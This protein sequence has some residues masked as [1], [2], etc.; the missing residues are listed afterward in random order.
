MP[1]ARTNPG[2]TEGGTVE[3]SLEFLSF[4][5]GSLHSLWFPNKAFYFIFWQNLIYGLEKFL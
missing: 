1:D 5:T 3:G 2:N 4:D